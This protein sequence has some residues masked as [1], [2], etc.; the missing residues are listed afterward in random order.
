MP[1]R[2]RP[3]SCSQIAK[4]G[5][6]FAISAGDNGYPSGG[7][8]DYGDL[9]SQLAGIFGLQFWGGVGSKLALFPAIGNHGYANNNQV[10]PHFANWPEDLAV[11]SSGGSAQVDPYGS[12]NGST[13]ANYADSWYAFSAGN[14]R[15]YILTAT[16]ADLNVG[17]GT[18]Y[19]DDYLA[20]W[21]TSS[22]E[23]LWLKAD[24]AAHPSGL[25]FAIFH[26]PLYSDQPS[27]NSDTYLQGNSSLEGLLASNG[28]NLAFSGHAHTYQRFSPATG[29]NRLSLVSYVTGGG[30]GQAQSLGTCSSNDKYGIGWSYTNNHGTACGAAPVP[31]SPAQVHH[32]LKVTINGN[33]VTVTPTD[34]TGQTFDIQ[35]YTFSPK[36]DTFL[37]CDASGR[38]EQHQRDLHVPCQFGERHV[39]VQARR[40][41]A[42]ACTSP[43][44][45]TGLANGPTPSRSTRPSAASPIRCR[46]T[47]TWTVDTIAPD[48]AGQ[49]RRQRRPRRSRC[50]SAGPRRATTSA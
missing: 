24:L 40:P 6:R 49:L 7:Q 3:A 14:A 42:G 20:H 8:N 39:H 48:G 17:T 45:Y 47:Y 36:P 16:W 15:F 10:H 38:L 12:I 22:P 9:Q 29:R 4:S 41:A 26:Y 31:A 25:K 30:G 34:S 13:P 37:D 27:E 28:V 2:T 44:T 35:T 5:A 23:Y 46:A 32:F 33:Q 43:K 18:V 19:G 1:T 50:R 21:T 11:S